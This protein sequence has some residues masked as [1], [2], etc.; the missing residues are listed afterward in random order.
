MLLT[1]IYTSLRYDLPS[2]RILIGVTCSIF[3]L[4]KIKSL[5]NFSEELLFFF[6]ALGAFNGLVLGSYFLFF[7]TPRSIS[8]R[9][10]GVLI[11]MLSIRVGKSVF[12]YFNPDL[13]FHYLQF[14]LTACLFIGP[15]LYFYT[16]SV[17]KPK[18]K[19]YRTWQWQVAGLAIIAF[20][21]GMLY[22]F[23]TNIELW[24]P[25]ILRGI[26]ITWFIYIIGA[27]YILR[28]P[29]KEMFH[30]NEKLN[31]LE[32][33]LLSLLVGNFLLATVYIVFDV[34]FYIAGALSFSFLIYLSLLFVFFNWKKRSIL[35]YGTSKYGDKKIQGQE[36]HLLTKK[37]NTLIK[38]EELF[39]N[40]DL[41]MSDVAKELHIL[42]H[43]LSQLIN[44]NLG[45]NFTLFIN[46]HR[47][48][49]AKKMIATHSN[50]KL[51]AIGYDCGFNSKSTFYSV[52]KRITGTTPSKYKESLS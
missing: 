31:S 29:L 35:L 18:D 24:R 9:F 49:E 32:V 4:I 16:A 44:D 51:E 7:A 52:F 2:Y 10:L 48:D 22:P 33:W 20:V 1:N 5:L 25:Y 40:A 39:K 13:D 42:P 26:Y 43:K 37:L 41:K 23:K 6:S 11:L 12:F 28:K 36:A 30:K 8:A 45:K 3:A 19:I 46:E 34:L 21:G 50:I 17:L 38:E 47:I 14:G 15:F 27:A